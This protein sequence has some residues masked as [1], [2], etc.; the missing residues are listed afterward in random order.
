ML[1]ELGGKVGELNEN[2]NRKLGNIKME[3]KT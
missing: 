3:I 1:S 2:F